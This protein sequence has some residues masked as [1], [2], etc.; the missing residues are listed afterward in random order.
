[1]YNE[2]SQ[3][4]LSYSIDSRKLANKL[5]RTHGEL[6]R[7][8]RNYI[9]IVKGNNFL[10]EDFFIESNYKDICGRKLP[11]YICTENGYN[12][13]KSCLLGKKGINFIVQQ[14][15]ELNKLKQE[16]LLKKASEES[17]NQIPFLEIIKSINIVAESLNL[18]QSEKIL[19]FR[20]FYKSYG[21]SDEFMRTDINN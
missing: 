9:Q 17:H 4:N 18:S 2:K 21:I 5:G 15:E 7:T 6:L 8:I 12:L 3:I 16:L 1:M 19:M 13:I 20:R 11:C 14:I 10:A